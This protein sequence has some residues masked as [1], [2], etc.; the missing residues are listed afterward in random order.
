MLMMSTSFHFVSIF[1]MHVKYTSSVCLVPSPKKTSQKRIDWSACAKNFISRENMAEMCKTAQHTTN[2]MTISPIHLLIFSRKC[3]NV[4]TCNIFQP[5]I[6]YNI[7]NTT[8]FN[9]IITSANICIYLYI[10]GL[11]HKGTM[12]AIPVFER[13]KSQRYKGRISRYV[14]KRH[15][16]F[17]HQHVL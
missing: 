12:S 1:C 8:T 17:W 6:R 16:C 9:N 3:I 11:Q 2:R 4:Y 14:D 13:K 10:D 7:K 15:S 5:N